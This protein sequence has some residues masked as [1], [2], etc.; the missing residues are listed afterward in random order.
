VIERWTILLFGFT[1]G[2]LVGAGMVLYSWGV[3]PWS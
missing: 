2:V 1:L 3:L